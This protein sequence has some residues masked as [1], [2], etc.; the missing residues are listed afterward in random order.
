MEENRTYEID[1]QFLLFEVIVPVLK[2]VK[3]L[4]VF[5]SSDTEIRIDMSLWKVTA[6]IN[7]IEKE[8]NNYVIHGNNKLVEKFLEDLLSE[9][10]KRFPDKGRKL[11]AFAL[12]H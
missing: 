11:P 4:S 6:L 12:G 3:E 10:N 7:F 2:S 5:L 9:L 8:K 1:E